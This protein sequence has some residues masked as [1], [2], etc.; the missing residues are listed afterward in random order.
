MGMS[1]H[2]LRALD[3]ETIGALINKLGSEDGFQ[4]RSARLAL[5][6]IDGPAV[7]GLMRALDHPSRDVRWEAAKALGEIKDPASAPALVDA[8]DDDRFGVRWLA[9]E[10][11]VALG[12]AALPALMKALS[13]QRCESPLLRQGAHHVL[14]S[15]LREH[16]LPAPA[17]R[18]LDALE[19]VE[20][21]VEVPG[22]ALAAYKALTGESDEPSNR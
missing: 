2:N 5:V 11:L 14:R 16:D 22:L 19:D 13:S 21:A 7:P 10:A 17:A 1:I 9:A 4:R 8:L 20:P 12:P 3:T 15:L 6:D 18:V